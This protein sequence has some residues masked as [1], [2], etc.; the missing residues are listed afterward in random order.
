MNLRGHYRVL[1]NL[2]HVK[3]KDI[4]RITFASAIVNSQEEIVKYKNNKDIV[5]IDFT[6]KTPIH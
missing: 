4:W 6:L 3:M 1:N 5:W 2:T